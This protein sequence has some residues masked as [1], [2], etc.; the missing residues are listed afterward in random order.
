MSLYLDYQRYRLEFWLAR[1][2]L[3]LRRLRASFNIAGSKD[4]AKTVGIAA[5]FLACI[6]GAGSLAVLN[7]NYNSTAHPTAPIA[8]DFYRTT[9]EQ[10]ETLTQAQAHARTQTQTT[11]E[12]IQ[13]AQNRR[14]ARARHTVSDT[15]AFEANAWRMIAGEHPEPIMRRVSSRTPHVLVIDLGHGVRDINGRNI[16]PGAT[17]K[18]GPLRG[19]GEIDFSDALAPHLQAAARERGI[20]IAFTRQAGQIM[21]N[22]MRPDQSTESG[23]YEYRVDGPGY[24]SDRADFAYYFCEQMQAQSCTMLSIHTDDVAEKYRPYASGFTAYSSPREDEWSHRLASSIA[25]SNPLGLSSSETN[26][27][28]LWVLN[29]FDTQ[30]DRGRSDMLT[31]AA[32]LEMGYTNHPDDL[33][34]LEQLLNNP[35]YA[36][37]VAENMID[38]YIRYLHEATA[39]SIQPRP[40][41]GRTA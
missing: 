32:L 5:T 17:V 22:P 38:G 41:P 15:T 14:Y 20:T 39:P 11:E 36:R 8:N 35:E 28:S 16:D 18:S 27:A 7:E 40:A 1:Q 23:F 34:H 33:A 25:E 12:S 29:R 30:S 21:I 37:E 9:Q 10:T 19:M 24:L 13:T 4:K 3:K 31:A 26:K 6:L 2:E